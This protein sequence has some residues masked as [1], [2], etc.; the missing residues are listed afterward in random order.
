M[1]IIDD[2]SD[3]NGVVI[4]C[5]LGGYVILQERNIESIRKEKFNLTSRYLRHPCPVPILQRLTHQL[6]LHPL[7]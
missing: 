1:T 6:I 2:I 4:I 3:G 5:G 7:F